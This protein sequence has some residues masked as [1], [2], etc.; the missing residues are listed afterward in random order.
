M[1]ANEHLVAWTE[2][3]EIL[4]DTTIDTADWQFATADVN[5]IHKAR[6]TVLLYVEL[7]YNCLKE[8]QVITYYH[9]FRGLYLVVC[10]IPNW[11]PSIH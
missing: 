1:I 5:H 3:D 4:G 11:L 7:K 10:E 8:T 2:P 6:Y 9:Y